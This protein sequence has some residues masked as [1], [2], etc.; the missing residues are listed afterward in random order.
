MQKDSRF[1]F[2]LIPLGLISLKLM[3]LSPEQLGS[4]GFV[5]MTENTFPWSDSV[6]I[7]RD[8]SL[9]TNIF[10]ADQAMLPALTDPDT[11][12]IYGM[13]DKEFIAESLNVSANMTMAAAKTDPRNV[14]YIDKS[15]VSSIEKL[16]SENPG[17]LGNLSQK[18]LGD[19]AYRFIEGQS[20]SPNIGTL[21]TADN[22]AAFQATFDNIMLGQAEE[23]LYEGDRLNAVSH[24]TS[25]AES[26]KSSSDKQAQA[27]SYQRDGILRSKQTA[28]TF[29]DFFAYKS[30]VTAT[31][32]SAMPTVESLLGN[33][34]SNTPR[35]EDLNGVFNKVI[36][37]EE[38]SFYEVKPPSYNI[39]YCESYVQTEQDSLL[40]NLPVHEKLGSII[41]DSN[42][43]ATGLA[44]VA[45]K[46]GQEGLSTAELAQILANDP[47]W[48]ELKARQ[49]AFKECQE[50]N[51][52]DELR[53]K[54]ESVVD[55]PGA[56]KEI[57]PERLELR[58][59]LALIIRDK[60]LPAN[61][62][63]LG[64]GRDFKS[65]GQSAFTS[66]DFNRIN[67]TLDGASGRAGKNLKDAK[68]KLVDEVDGVTKKNS[69]FTNN[70]YHLKGGEGRK[71][72]GVFYRD[73]NGVLRGPSGKPIMFSLRPA[74]ENIFQVISS[75]Y[76]KKFFDQNSK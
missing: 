35:G 54:V 6:Q 68:A 76:Q 5:T 22:E 66:A 28:E 51:C 27:D 52:L 7:A 38:L 60:R 48:N 15:L 2:V 40:K 34:K 59:N 36:S 20:I 65:N 21:Q 10:F 33:C 57:S 50:K 25:K 53:A 39:D 62:A 46:L 44:G 42:R 24:F 26:F 41:D 13:A 16:S 45:K 9:N 61:I 70:S 64:S 63:G 73:E 37:R 49:E 17:D 47:A 11:N 56:D 75:R 12:Y 43:M 67:S 71:G 19:S 1:R 4:E 72:R 58:K 69:A 29:R 8:P 14:Q 74:H 23:A 31:N 18:Q 3:A 32:L 55:Y 30:D